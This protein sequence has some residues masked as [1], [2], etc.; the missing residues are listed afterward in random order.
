M[1]HFL[2]MWTPQSGWSFSV[3]E[4]EMESIQWCPWI[5]ESNQPM[6]TNLMSI[7]NSIR[8]KV[9]RIC[10][11][12]HIIFLWLE[13]LVICT[14]CIYKKQSWNLIYITTLPLISLSPSIFRY[15]KNVCIFIV[16]MQSL[17]K[18]CFLNL[19]Y[20]LLMSMSQ[21]SMKGKR[22][23]DIKNQNFITRNRQMKNKYKNAIKLW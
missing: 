22:V 3:L 9:V 10:F 8:H 18:D 4:A 19:N 17:F 20:F 16:Y 5:P 12:I 11:S 1:I 13:I 7:I 23:Y 2:N 6:L 14:S 21:K 15:E